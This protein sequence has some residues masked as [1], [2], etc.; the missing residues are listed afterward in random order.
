MD[1]GLLIQY[2][3]IVLAVLASALYVLNRQLPRQMRRLRVVLAVPLVREGRPRWLVAI[4]HWAA[5][6]AAGSSNACGGCDG[7]GTTGTATPRQH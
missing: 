5:P 4:G 6:A 7:C 2:G 1:A 3:V